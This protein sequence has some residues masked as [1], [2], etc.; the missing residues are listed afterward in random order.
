MICVRCAA[1]I[2]ANSIPPTIKGNTEINA[3]F[4]KTSNYFNFNMLR[5]FY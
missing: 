5:Y 1:T 2:N 3:H 4:N